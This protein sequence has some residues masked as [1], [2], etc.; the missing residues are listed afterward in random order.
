MQLFEVLSDLPEYR[1]ALLLANNDG[2]E[3]LNAEQ[4]VKFLTK[5]QGFDGID[6]K[7]AEAIIAYCEP[8]AEIKPAVLTINGFRRLLQ[9]RWG[10]ILKPNHENIFMDMTKPLF[11]YYINSSH[12]TYLTGLQVRG[13]ATV[14]G[15]ISALRKGARLLECE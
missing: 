3:K 1:N 11:D 2:E 12:N 10:Y 9:S 5:E 6:I 14:E 8:A 13:E 7:K 15:Y 4:L